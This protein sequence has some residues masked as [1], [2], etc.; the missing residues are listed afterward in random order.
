MTSTTAAPTSGLSISST[1]AWSERA[2]SPVNQACDVG[3]GHGTEASGE[4]CPRAASRPMAASPSALTRTGLA[5]TA[6]VV[7]AP[8]DELEGLGS[9]CAPGQRAQLGL[10]AD[11][12]RVGHGD[13]ARAGQGARAA[14]VE[15]HQRDLGRGRAASGGLG[16]RDHE[17]GRARGSAAAGRPRAA[18]RC[19]AGPWAAGPRAGRAGSS[20]CSPV[21]PPGR[22]AQDQHE[23]QPGE[24]DDEE[25]GVHPRRRAGH[26]VR[27]ELLLH[28][29]GPGAAVL[30]A[31]LA[32]PGGR[33][34]GRGDLTVGG[35]R[36]DDVL[37]A[38]VAELGGRRDGRPR[39]ERA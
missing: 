15:V 13:L 30:G 37:D 23:Q 10:A 31:G 34:E 27:V 25:Q 36:Q 26:G 12:G 38:G 28:Q 4:S 14:T 35:R 17:Q 8:C 2:P 39:D 24:L 3:T 9:V 29:P 11:P 1:E 20:R 16:P 21:T 22:A 6:P 5:P 33:V 18:S 19:R 7:T 32:E